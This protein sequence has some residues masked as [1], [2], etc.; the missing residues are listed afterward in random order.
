MKKTNFTPT[1]RIMNRAEQKAARKGSLLER[2]MDSSAR[3]MSSFAVI[4]GN[5]P[6]TNSSY[7][8]L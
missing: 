2:V 8:Q 3:Y 1:V 4:R 6:S 7:F 5:M